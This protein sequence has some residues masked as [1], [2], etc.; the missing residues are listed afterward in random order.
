MVALHNS[1]PLSSIPD[2]VFLKTTYYIIE[3]LI[4]T[5]SAL[6]QVMNK[7]VNFPAPLFSPKV[8][9]L[10]PWCPVWISVLQNEVMSEWIKA[11]NIYI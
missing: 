1:Y 5:M 8:I 6:F 9:T 2:N 7:K 3:L 4:R 11:R 10:W